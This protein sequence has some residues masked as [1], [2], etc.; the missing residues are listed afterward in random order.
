MDLARLPRLVV[1][2]SGR[3]TTIGGVCIWLDYHDWW[4]MYLAG[5]PRLVVCGS[6][7]ITTIGGV[8][9]WPD[10]HDWWCMDLAGLPRLVVCGS[11]QI[12][13][14]VGRCE[15]SHAATWLLRRVLPTYNT[16]QAVKAT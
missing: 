16:T 12:M 9:I 6:G 5:L 1:C 7:R 2:G 13:F 14:C 10:Y 3:I 11:G 4:C 8:W 15:T